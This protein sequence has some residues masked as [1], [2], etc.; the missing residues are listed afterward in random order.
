MFNLGKP[1][2]YSLDHHGLI[3]LE[4]VYWNLPRAQLV[5]HA[6]MNKEVRITNQGAIC[7]ETGKHTGRSPKDKYIVNNLP[8][9]DLPIWWGEINQPIPEGNF[10]IILKK[11]QAYLQHKNVYVQDLWTGAHPDYRLPIRVITETAWHSLFAQNLFIDPPIEKRL[12]LIPEFTVLMSPNFKLD[13]KDDGVRSETFIGV[14]YTQKIVLIVNSGYAGEIKKSIFSVMNYL[15]P[16]RHVLPMHCSANV[17]KDKDVA[18]FFGLSGTGKTTLSSS[19]DRH[20]IGDDEHGWSEEG[21]FNFEGGCYAKAINLQKELEPAIWNA[22]NHFGSVLENVMVDPFTGVPDFRDDSLTENTRSAYPLEYIPDHVAEGFAGHPRNIFFLSADAFGV[23]P[24]IA[25]LDP[26]QAMYFFLSGYTA[27]LAG[28]ERGL[29][30]EPQ[31]TFSACFGAPFLPLSPTIYADMLKEKIKKYDAKVWLVNTGWSGGEYGVGD[32]MKL[33]WT[34]AL[35]KAAL[36]NE[37]DKISFD[38]EPYFDLQIPQN[39]PGVPAEILNPINTWQDKEMY[40]K[41][42]LALKSSFA[43]NYQTFHNEVSTVK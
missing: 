9:E 39:C 12:K 29:G 26:E 28:T 25:K 33:S 32:R 22:T 6:V 8:P 17:G 14:D 15:L 23:M 3:N 2:E 4:N 19:A 13:P 21:V 37:F 42:A 34:R 18:L 7:A 1:G 30:K 43:Q 5:E 11:F 31:A 27:K 36:D 10:N 41:K 16:H 24:P 38:R 35:I 20:L 40:K